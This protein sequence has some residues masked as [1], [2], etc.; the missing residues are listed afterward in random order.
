MIMKIRQGFQSSR[1]PNVKGISSD[2]RVTAGV[3]LPAVCA[4]GL[5]LG[6]CGKANTVGAAPA[7]ASVAASTTAS[8]SSV[9]LSTTPSQPTT[10]TE[11]P[12]PA[13]VV[14]TTTAALKPAPPVKKVKLDCVG[15]NVKAAGD[16]S[17]RIT[18][19]TTGTF[20]NLKNVVT[21]VEENQFDEPMGSG[22]G[23]SATAVP[24]YAA[25]LNPG[26]QAENPHA[27]V[28]VIDYNPVPGGLPSPL[29]TSALQAPDAAKA[30]LC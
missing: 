10:T 13:P 15:F 21:I 11:T 19:L 2:H 24:Q 17:K 12:P 8:S 20:P 7:D 27:K 3:L 16:G 28:T 14:T 9:E 1:N 25:D 5:A 4:L 22:R 29:P 6:A 26:G 30:Y 18:A 23:L